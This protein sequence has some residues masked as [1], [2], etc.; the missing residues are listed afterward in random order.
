MAAPA[1]GRGGGFFSSVLGGLGGALAGNWLYDQFAGGHHSNY[2]SA[3]AGHVPNSAGAPTKEEM[4]LSA[5][6]TTRAVG[7]H[8]MTP[9]VVVTA[10]E[11]T[12]AEV[13]TGA[14]AEAETGAE[15]EETG[16]ARLNLALP[17]W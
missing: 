15:A 14:E 3:D 16:K 4:R 9:A 17:S 8:G 12:G 5:Q 11:E 2:G 10:A 13:A 7:H 6:T 1:T